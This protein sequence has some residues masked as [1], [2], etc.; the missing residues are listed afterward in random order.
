MFYWNTLQCS[1]SLAFRQKMGYS[2]LTHLLTKIDNQSV[3]NA[4]VALVKGA[5]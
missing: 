4:G 1:L 2:I 5:N 3:E